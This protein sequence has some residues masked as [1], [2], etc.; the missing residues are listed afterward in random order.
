MT[1]KT[2]RNYIKEMFG[3]ITEPMMI[4]LCLFT[5]RAFQR[6]WAWQLATSNSMIYS[7][8]RFVVFGTTSKIIFA[9]NFAFFCFGILPAFFPA[10]KFAFFCF[11]V[12]G[13]TFIIAFFTQVTITVFPRFVFGKFRERFNFFAFITAF[14]LNCLRHGRFSLNSERL[15]L[16]PVSGY[17]P[18]SG[19]FYYKR[20]NL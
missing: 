14:C 10:C 13:Y 2:N 8:Y 5:T 3:F 12:L 7:F 20:P 1:F 9:S 11:L 15:C 16:E 6:I 18:V 17:I 4:F 19:S